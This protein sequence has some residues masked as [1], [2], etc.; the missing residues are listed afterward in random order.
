MVVLAQA[1]PDSG[2]W[3]PEIR[4]AVVTGAV[5]LLVAI[6]G[7]LAT[8]RVAKRSRESAADTAEKQRQHDAAMRA[9]DH[10]HEESLRRAGRQHEHRVTFYVDLLAAILR[11][12]Q[13]MER[14]VPFA[15]F[16]GDPGP[17]EPLGDDAQRLI[18]AKVD[19]LASPEVRSIVHRW[20]EN[21][22]NFNLH[23][24]ELVTVR[25]RRKKVSRPDDDTRE[26]TA[27]QGQLTTRTNAHAIYAELAAQVTEELSA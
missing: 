2:F 17:P 3:T 27:L 8:L 16:P 19:A 10:S 15:E 11:G 26:L 20:Q 9:G 25:E 18:T 4:A 5:A 6:V 7:F 21:L 12:N 14:T 22:R 23:T 1:A 24:I 13:S